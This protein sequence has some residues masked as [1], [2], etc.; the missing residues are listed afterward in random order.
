[1][2][3]RAFYFS[4]GVVVFASIRALQDVV[5]GGFSGVPAFQF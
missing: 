4:D 5:C 3:V 2:I 1:M